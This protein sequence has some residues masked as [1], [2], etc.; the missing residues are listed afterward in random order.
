[1]GMCG[2]VLSCDCDVA[3][4]LGCGRIYGCAVVDLCAVLIGANGSC[5]GMLCV[6]LL[7]SGVG[8]DGSLSSVCLVV[9]GCI[10]SPLRC[11][12]SGCDIGCESRWSCSSRSSSA[13][14]C[15]WL[16]SCAGCAAIALFSSLS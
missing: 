15:V 13:V 14:T 12:M 1:M 11:C 10:R 4:V 5:F 2:R 16:G 3:G 6:W 7:T 8:I 9:V